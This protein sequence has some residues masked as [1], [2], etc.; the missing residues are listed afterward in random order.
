MGRRLFGKADCTVNDEGPPTRREPQDPADDNEEPEDQEE[1]TESSGEPVVGGESESESEWEPEPAGL[2]ASWFGSRTRVI[3]LLVG[4]VFL[5][6][7]FYIAIDSGSQERFGADSAAAAVEE[8][9]EA[10][11]NEDVVAALRVMAPSEVGTFGDMYS[12]LVELA[13]E[14]GEIEN[15]NWLAGLDLEMAGL[16]TRTVELHPGVALVEMRSGT[17]SM[18]IDADTAD[19]AFFDVGETEVAITV[20]EMREAMRE[21]EDSEGLSE[22]L[23]GSR[24]ALEEILGTSVDESL[25]IHAPRD[26]VFMMT[27]E[28]GGRWYVSP[29]YTV[30]EYIRQILDL[31]PADF[32]LSREQ[33]K[34]GASSPAGVVD[35][36]VE[37]VNSYTV[38][39]HL[40]ALLNG[41]PEGIFDPF[42][43]FSPY[44]E[45]GVFIDYSPSLAAYTEE[46][47][48]A[49]QGEQTQ[50]E[51]AAE[52]EE[53]IDAYEIEGQ[54]SLTV[55]VREEER[56]DGNVVLYLESGTINA[57]V[58]AILDPDYDDVT[59]AEIDASWD[60]LCVEISVSVDGEPGGVEDCVAAELRPEGLDEI[61]VVVGEID[62]SWYISYVETVLAYIDIFLEDQLKS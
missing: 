2:S 6:V 49:L 11:S 30:A 35:G 16:E 5:A 36:V 21:L 46:A 23:D 27:V 56:Q 32:S 20:E 28:R 1:R 3:A 37:V 57:D 7:V 10:M 8:M 33:A 62:G 38:E 50:E 60:G 24:E 39:Q 4:F 15:E 48:E 61:F 9:A 13:V 26:G 52:L 42:A 14:E 31:P 40:E 59:E 29:F 43:V 58:S 51:L 19:T 22:G 47:F 34:P 55:N 44:D 53:L 18:A 25:A 12:R 17:L 54:V 41:D 45:L